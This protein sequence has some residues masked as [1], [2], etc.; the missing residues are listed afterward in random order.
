MV[1]ENWNSSENQSA[2]CGIKFSCGRGYRVFSDDLAASI[3][4]SI[5]QRRVGRLTRSSGFRISII[6]DTDAQYWKKRTVSLHEYFIRL[7]FL[8]HLW[9]QSPNESSLCIK[10][11]K[12][13]SSSY[14]R[15]A[16]L[17][18]IKKKSI[19]Y[20]VMSVLILLSNAKETVQVSHRKG[21]ILLWDLPGKKF[22]SV[23]KQ[24][25]LSTVYTVY[26]IDRDWREGPVYTPSGRRPPVL[27][28]ESSFLFCRITPN[29]ISF[30]FLF[31]LHFPR[32]LACA[33]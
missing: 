26:S 30:F 23:T 31:P 10:N 9:F 20:H 32:S 25:V 22:F 24:Y 7:L 6:K 29:F 21:I 11:E 3:F 14:R 28:T 4:I 1:D 13:N 33:K 5:H 17:G 18:Y 12:K 8:L 2:Y 16:F 15:D 27:S 19:R